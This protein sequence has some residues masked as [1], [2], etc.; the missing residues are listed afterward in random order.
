MA[1]RVAGEAAVWKNRTSILYLTAAILFRV[2]VFLEVV[3][4]SS[5]RVDRP[6]VEDFEQVKQTV[7]PGTSA[8]QCSGRRWGGPRC[9]RVGVTF[10]VHVWSWTWKRTLWICDTCH[11]CLKLACWTYS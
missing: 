10:W 6:E 5:R 1:G 4:S 11:S 7:P 3:L 9:G 8:A 2:L